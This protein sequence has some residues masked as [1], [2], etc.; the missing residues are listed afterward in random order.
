[1]QSKECSGKYCSA[2]TRVYA[3]PLQYKEKAILLIAIE[4]NIVTN[5]H[6]QSPPRPLTLTLTDITF[7][8]LQ[9]K[10]VVAPIRL[11]GVPRSYDRQVLLVGDAAGHVDPLTGEGIHTA[12][13]AGKIAAQAVAEMFATGNF[14][15][16]SGRAYG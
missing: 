14:S 4:L 12:M 1:V 6:C 8:S 5:H 15:L 9:E 13:I 2:L 11:G 16:E 3:A 10:R 7:L